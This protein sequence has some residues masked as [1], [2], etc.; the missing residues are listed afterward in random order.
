MGWW[1]VIHARPHEAL[2]PYSAWPSVP[3]TDTPAPLTLCKTLDYSTSE[4]DCVCVCVCVSAA[5]LQHRADASIRNTDGKT[6]LDVAEPLAAQVL[7][8]EYKRSELLQ[9]AR[10][11]TLS[12]PLSVWDVGHSHFPS[13]TSPNVTRVI[14]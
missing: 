10:S 12:P 2:S 8:G 3:V 6:A 1:V 4:R 13:S 7:S 9:A 11:A 14:V 5:L